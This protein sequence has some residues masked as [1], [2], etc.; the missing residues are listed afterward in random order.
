MADKFYVPLGARETILE[1]GRP[2]VPGEE[3]SLSKEDMESEFNKR[4]IESGTL[5][6]TKTEPK[7][8]DSEGGDG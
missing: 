3:V 4:L 8:K 1:S 5:R 2:L 6:S 7:P